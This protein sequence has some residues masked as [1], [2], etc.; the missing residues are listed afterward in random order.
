MSASVVSGRYAPPV[1][2]VSEEIFHP[3]PDPIGCFAELDCFYAIFLRWDTWRDLLFGQQITDFVAVISSIADQGFNLGNAFEQHIRTFEVTALPF[4][5]MEPDGPPDIVA[6]GTQLGVQATLS[7]PDQPRSVAPRFETGCRAM[8]LEASGVYHKANVVTA[9]RF[10][11]FLEDTFEH[12]VF[13][14]SPEP[15]LLRFMRPY[16]AGASAHDDPFFMT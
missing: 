15:I 10:G 5:Q 9:L 14:P 13:S 12:A 6:R 16:S 11:Q 1:L 2:Q 3:V 4:V 8:G 7:S